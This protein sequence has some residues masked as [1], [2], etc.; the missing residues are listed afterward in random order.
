MPDKRVHRFSP[1]EEL[2]FSQKGVFCLMEKIAFPVLAVKMVPL[3]QIHANHYNPNKVAEPELELLE[4]SIREDGFTQPLVCYFDNEK[5]GYLLI[6]GFHRYQV[7]KER[8]NL[9]EVPVTVIDKPLEHRMASTVR[10]NRARGTHGIEK[11]SKIVQQL[12]ASGW[13]DDRI[14]KELGME[15]EEVFRF[16]QSSGLKSAFSNHQ[17]SRSWTDFEK[18]Y[19]QKQEEPENI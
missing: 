11:M 5:E 6:D 17:F 1:N 10:H 2:L 12:V 16:K 9:K 3:I 8:L 13:T 7:A 18:K 14:A 19:Y 4:L 15:A